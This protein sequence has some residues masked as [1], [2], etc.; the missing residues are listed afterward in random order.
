MS[1][2]N[3]NWIFHNSPFEMLD[4]AFRRLFPD[5][6]YISEWNSSVCKE[7]NGNKV[8]GLT[9]FEDTGEIV[10]FVDPHLSV[11]DAIEIFAHEL[12]H[13]AVGSE[14]GHDE[15]WEKAFDD[16][17]DE[18][19]KVGEEIFGASVEKTPQGADYI[20]ML[21]ELGIEP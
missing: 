19:N 16:L 12:A 2:D 11:N 1:I 18:Y 5:I 17:F 7:E 21:E 14:H 13:A 6:E 4:I 3:S 15:V 8:C 9:N 10:I 20:E